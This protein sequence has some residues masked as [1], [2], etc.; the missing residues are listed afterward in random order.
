[1]SNCTS[2]ILLKYF[3]L[4]H[5]IFVTRVEIDK[6]MQYDRKCING[7]ILILLLLLVACTTKDDK[8]KIM[9]ETVDLKALETK[10]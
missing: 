6:I 2:Y 3:S 7:I 4:S 1:M 8:D 10:F 5:N 9:T